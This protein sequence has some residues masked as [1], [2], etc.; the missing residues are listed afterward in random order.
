MLNPEELKIIVYPDPRLKKP[1][2]R[3]E[4][5]DAEL[6]AL[7]TRM[8]QL[9]RE[10]KG[11]GLAAPQ[12]GVDLQVFVMNATGNPEDDRVYVNPSLTEAAGE[13]TEEEGCLSLPGI[14]INVPRSK[15][16]R[17]D[18]QDPTGQAIRDEAAGYIARIWQH[19]FDHL[20]GTLLTDRMG[21]VDRLKYRKTVKE[22]EDAWE[23]GHPKVKA[24]T[25]KKRK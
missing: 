25:R 20:Q 12:V 7:I 23:K 14:R 16:L 8:F 19:E 10:A 15:S 11:V 6:Q 18:A 2:K 9:M 13:E 5:F 21:P 22:L 3:A 4:H 24:K 17:I 1:S